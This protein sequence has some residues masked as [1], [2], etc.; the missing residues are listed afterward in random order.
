VDDRDDLDVIRLGP[1]NVI[2]FDSYGRYGV[3]DFDGD[4]IDDLFLATGKTWWYSSS[5]EFQW[6]YLSLRT[7][8][9]NDVRLGYFDNDDRCDVLAEKDGEWVISSGGTGAW[10]SIGAFGAPLSEVA[11][12]RFDPH[13]RDHRRGINRRTTH[14]FWRRQSGRWQLTSLSARDWLDVQ[15]SSFP[16][17]RLRFGDFTGDGVTD[18]L[19]VQDGRWS[20]SQSGTGRW[21]RLNEYLDDDVRS[22]FIVDLNNNNIDDLLRLERAEAESEM[23][24]RRSRDET[25]TWFVSYDG[26]TPWRKLT[27]YTLPISGRATFAYA[28]RFGTAPGGGVLLIDPERVG[29]F[30]SAAESGAGAS[31]SWTSRFPY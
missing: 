18:V 12:G 15:S 10:K 11:F 27:S 17:N 22:L 6:T 28:G 23:P 20:I 3:C 21:E 9:L 24:G 30:Y 26:R 14:A 16:M 4:T 29:R 5:G 31:P 1:R 8:R 13:I 7:E 19:A 2:D 25:F